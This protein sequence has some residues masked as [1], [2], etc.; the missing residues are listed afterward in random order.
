V[1]AP[2]YEQIH[3]DMLNKVAKQV[4]KPGQRIPSEMELCEIYGVSRITIRKAIED[5]VRSGHLTRYRGKGTFVQ[6]ELIENRLSK[7]YSFSETLKS[8]GIHE[9]AEILAFDVVGADDHLTNILDLKAA[10]PDERHFVY[11]ITRL[12]SVDES[13]YAVESSYIPKSLLPDLTEVHVRENGLYNAMRLCGVMPDK[14]KETFQAVASRGLEAKLLQ[15]NVA[16]PAMAIERVTYSGS[17]IVEYCRSI[18][19]GDFFA[20]TVELG[21]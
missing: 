7:F 14:A 8:K 6:A 17:V 9:L 16:A 10:Y 20:Y 21:N 3:E 18:V 19:R 5:M 11:K 4:W 13:P 15:Q 12:R 1:L 2:L